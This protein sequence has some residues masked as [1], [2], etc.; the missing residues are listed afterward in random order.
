M[1]RG[2]RPSEARAS[3]RGFSLA[4][5]LLAS[6]ML[7]TI[8]LGLGAVWARH[9]RAT[10]QS[11]DLLVASSWAQTVMEEQLSKGY[12]CTSKPWTPSSNQQLQIKHFTS[13]SDGSGQVEI[14]TEYRYGVYV[15]DHADATNPGLKNVEVQVSWENDGIWRTQLL[16]TRLSWQG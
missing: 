5:A 4:E 2:F 15:T 3:S 16:R 1:T 12:T 7:C 6:V 8:A 14:V 10:T 9:S 11:R 13:S